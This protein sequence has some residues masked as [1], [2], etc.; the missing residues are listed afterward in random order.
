MK[1]YEMKADHLTPEEIAKRL[2]AADADSDRSLESI[3]SGMIER[4]RSEG[5]RAVLDYTAR[6]DGAEP[7]GMFADPDDLIRAKDRIE[8][9]EP[10]L[11]EALKLAIHRVRMYHEKQKQE[12]FWLQDEIGAVM[13]QMVRPLARVGIY[14]PGGTAAYPSTVYMNVIPA[15]VA[16]VKE[17]VLATPVGPD[18][19]AN[20]IVM[21]VATMLGI[22]K[23]LLSGGAQAIAALA[24]GTESVQKVDKI[25]GPGNRYV[26]TAKRLVFGAVDIDMIAGPSE[27]LVIADST[28]DP[29][30]VAADL[31]SQ[32]EHDPNARCILL[33]TDP[34]LKEVVAYELENQ[35]AALPRGEICRQAIEQNGAIVLAESLDEAIRISNYLAPEHLSVQTEA[36]MDLLPHI[37][38]AGSVFLGGYTPEA[39]GDYLAGPNHTL[40]TSGT[41][42]FSSPLSVSDFLKKSSFTYFTKEAFET[43]APSIVRI[44]EEE[45]LTAHANAVTVRLEN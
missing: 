3:V 4:V 21:A 8:S 15:L 30:A 25:T 33:T 39:L 28:A 20:E 7:A 14:I 36:P 43:L 10:A 11:Y 23:I 44:A 13:G 38:N 5:D 19:K 26:A 41:A 18:G 42:R 29:K 2:E 24:Y 6:F 37:T 12:G 40:P 45:G 31:L 17:I 35:M 27:I 32:A 16:G 1:I 34:A 9:E 22:E